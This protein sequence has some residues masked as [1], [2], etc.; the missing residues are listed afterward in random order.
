MI[1]QLLIALMDYLAS[2]LEGHLLKIVI[3]ISIHDAIN[4]RNRIGATPLSD[5]ARKYLL[6]PTLRTAEIR[7]ETS[8]T[9]TSK[10]PYFS[11]GCCRE[12]SAP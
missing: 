7:A 6:K 1:A 3:G 5:L 8:R 4:V 11:L 12:A 10:R 2:I 9:D